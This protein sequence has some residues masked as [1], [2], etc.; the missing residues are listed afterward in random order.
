MTTGIFNDRFLSLVES[1]SQAIKE[2]VDLV[3]ENKINNPKSDHKGSVS[4]AA[5]N[6]VQSH[7]QKKS[8][9]NAKQGLLGSTRCPAK[10]YIPFVDYSWGICKTC[11][12]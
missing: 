10:C 12:P 5:I 7:V 11:V 1:L 9:N 4:R 3:K 8:R 6:F 2:E